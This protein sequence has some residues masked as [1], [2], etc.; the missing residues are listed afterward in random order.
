MPVD[1][2]RSFDAIVVGTGFAG[3]VTACRLVEAGFLICVLERGRRYGR[4]D[5]PKYP[6]DELFASGEGADNRFAP[7][8]DFS[9]WLW[10]SDN[11]I[12][13]I[14]DL[15]DV[16][17]VQAAGY[18][19]GSLIYANVH[20][21][22]PR[23]V[24]QRDWPDEYKPAGEEWSLTPYFD[25]AAYMLRVSAVPQKLAK[26]LQLQRAADHI[27]NTPAGHWFRTPL[28]VNFER[29]GPNDYGPEQHPCDMRGE[30]WM[31]CA[32]LA[33]NTLDMNYLARAEAGS[34]APDIRTLAEV[35][36]IE[37]DG[38]R[39]KVTYRDLLRAVDDG[40][41]SAQ[42]SGLVTVYAPY[43]FLCAGSVGTTEL[44]LR[45]RS[46]LKKAEETKADETASRALGSHYFPNADSFSIVFNCEEPHEGDYGPTITS[47]LLFQQPAQ[48]AYSQSLEFED[49][50][51]VK[52][53]AKPPI[54]GVE[55]RGTKS[56]AT[57]R[58][59]ASPV[60]DWGSWTDDDKAAGTL[61]LDEIGDEAFID[62]EEIEIGRTATA[63]VRSKIVRHEHWFLVE[64][65][66]Y[67]PDLEP[68]LGVFRSPLWLRRNRY[69]EAAAPRHSSAPS[70]RPVQSL[71]VQGF[72]D[73]LGGAS[74]RTVTR[75]ALRGAN[76]ESRLLF[77]A[78]LQ[79][80]ARKLFPDW[81]VDTVESTHREFLTQTASAALP[82]L[83][84]LMD[85]LAR[86]LATQLKPEMLSSLGVDKAGDVP[87]KEV[88]IR[89]M[90][91]QGVQIL[92]G[93][94]AT[95][96]N[97]AAELFLEQIPQNP[98]KL[99]EL[100]GRVLLWAL[101]YGQTDGHTGMLLTM[102]RDLYRGRLRLDDASDLRARLPGRLIDVSSVVQE[103]VL[104]AIA[105]DGWRGE[106][107]TNPAWTPLNRRVTVHSQGGCPMGTDATR[108]VTNPW[109]EVHG[110]PGLYVM[111]AAAFPTSV[112]VNP[113][114][115][116][117]A[118]AEYKIEHFLQQPRPE[119]LRRRGHAHW[120]SD[121]KAKAAKWV[122]EKGRA[123]LDPLNGLETSNPRLEGDTI[124]FSF[125]E[126]MAGFLSDASHH[127][128]TK[129]GDLVS[130]PAT[131]ARFVECE[132]KGAGSGATIT[133]SLQ[134][135]VRD[136]AELVSAERAAQPPKVC[137]D[138]TVT[139]AGPTSPGTYKV[140][141][142]FLQFFVPPD[143]DTPPRT[144][145]FRYCMH[146]DGPRGA[147]RFDGLKVL[148]DDPH[149]DVWHDTTTL[150]FEI[151]GGPTV[152]RGVLRL[153]GQDFFG[154]QVQSFTIGGTSDPTREAWALAAFYKYFGSE[155]VAIY[156]GRVGTMLTSLGKAIT[157]IHV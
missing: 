51:L 70:R 148:R 108:S 64:E 126:S 33:K 8:P 62:G 14:R 40:S 97:K 150:Y 57:A 107:R 61:V 149:F 154:R 63:K 121:D 95:V 92:A 69:L 153:T 135:R 24:F 56:D 134:A 78:V 94:E 7:P 99:L 128:Q 34:P 66:G 48:G 96:A 109:G 87:D 101:G 129:W 43:V 32:R 25:L 120:T 141:K 44:L 80:Q 71:R 26:T 6:V 125:D 46:L 112:G 76:D 27:P 102:G 82:M 132:T 21:R 39:F 105:R 37:H 35:I 142:G 54:A 1:D 93:S 104:R 136:L 77:G 137:L 146:L 114:A 55:I 12:Y 124:T 116:I 4:D 88:V 74:T 144:R 147:R 17:A 59:S 81:F 15:D 119:K 79:E 67:P 111:D 28:A 90:I 50:H 123:E 106:L 22:P 131:V 75:P 85:E 10:S 72:T 143:P 41:G 83:G 89:G 157:S 53:D 84:Q 113:S 98:A 140:T 115:T 5:F 127:V 19:G 103:R 145:F 139:I 16:I 31:G 155:L 151:S 91:R 118:V 138:G 13:D 30:C 110:R 38:T 11:G 133:T 45:N 18:G 100:L 117:A 47:A 86:T 23:K 122:D 49:G 58:L 20:L 60:I 42:T 52:K 9:R 68:L 36:S 29:D 156:S 65:G 73:A 152:E 3:A 2:R 130:F